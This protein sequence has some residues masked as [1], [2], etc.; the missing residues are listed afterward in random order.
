M[1]PSSRVITSHAGYRRRAKLE[2]VDARWAVDDVVEAE[3]VPLSVPTV[4]VLPEATVVPSVEVGT[5]N[6]P[7]PLELIATVPTD[8][9]LMVTATLVPS[10]EVS[11]LMVITAS[12]VPSSLPV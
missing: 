8:T 4:T 5:V 9:P 12:C 11:P 2:N 10:A 6:V 7:L 3:N 1:T